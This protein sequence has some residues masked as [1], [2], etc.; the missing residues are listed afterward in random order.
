M[1]YVGQSRDIDGRRTDHLSLLRRGKHTN[2]RFQRAFLRDGEGAFEFSVLCLCSPDDLNSEEQKQL[3]DLSGMYN[4]SHVAQAN[5]AGKRDEEAKQNI[6]R[7]VAESLARDPGRAARQGGTLRARYAADSDLR[8]MAGSGSRGR[9]QSDDERRKKSE[10]VSRTKSDPAH[11]ARTAEK[12]REMWQDP[13]FRR[14]HAESMARYRSCVEPGAHAE[15]IRKAKAEKFADPAYRA[16]ISQKLK[17][18]WAR[19]KQAT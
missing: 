4:F 13:E 19:R 3:G 2:R 10:S 7:G 11:K 18:A 8:F 12:S 17:D 15:R 5:G 16:A 14:R 1:R 9:S 6:R